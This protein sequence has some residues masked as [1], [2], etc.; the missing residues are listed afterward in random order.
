MQVMYCPFCGGEAKPEKRNSGYQVRCQECSARGTYFPAVNTSIGNGEA[1]EK[2]I[3]AWNK[4]ST[5]Y[6]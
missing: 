6:I 1:K 3:E 5:P 4:R 2:A